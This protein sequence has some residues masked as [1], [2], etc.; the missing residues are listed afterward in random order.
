[1]LTIF[2]KRGDS[3]EEKI[4]IG[5]LV[6][7]LLITPF[8]LDLTNQSSATPSLEVKKNTADAKV[9]DW[10]KKLAWPIA[11]KAGNYFYNVDASFTSGKYADTVTP[12]S[13]YYNN[14]TYGTSSYFDF[15]F[16]SASH[17]VNMYADTAIWNFGSNISVILTNPNG[18][19]VRNRSVDPTQ[20]TTYSPGV[21]GTYRAQYVVNKKEKWTPYL[22]YRADEGFVTSAKVSS[23]FKNYPISQDLETDI[24]NHF[25][26][27]SKYGNII[28]P[29][30]EHYQSGENTVRSLS[31]EGTNQALTADELDKQYYDNKL[32]VHVY[33]MKDYNAGD[34]VHFEDTIQEIKFDKEANQTIFT[35]EGGKENHNVKFK[36][37]I[38]DLYETGDTLQLEFKVEKLTDEYP[39]LAVID[40][41]KHILDKDE[42][43]EIDNYLAN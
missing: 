2:L 25:V 39:D 41:L 37:N 38:T 11:K 34:T 27:D 10:I 18:T 32:N 30:K 4:A 8:S 21:T 29:S 42:V 40:Y 7:G 14:G 26:T 43:P 33:S 6:G 3:F 28:T 15:N 17:S 36:G 1:M 13:I 9:A 23:D 5:T 20:W 31:T 16:V 24:T 12:G 19:Y 22:V 35:F